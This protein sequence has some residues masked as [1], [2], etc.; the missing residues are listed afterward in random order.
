MKIYQFISYKTFLQSCF[1]DISLKKKKSQLAQFLNC[2][3]GFIS[4]ALSEGKTHFT[5]E[6]IYKTG[7]FFNLDEKEINYLILLLQ[8][9]KAGTV[10]LQKHFKNQID[11]MQNENK[12]ITTRIKKSNRKL[13]DH[14]KA[15]Y[16]S[17]WAYMA[18][19]MSVSLP[20][21]YSQK[22]IQEH[23]HINFDFCNSVIQFLLE[24]G[25]IEKNGNKLS[26]GKTRIHLERNSP[27]VKSLHQNWRQKAIE[28]LVDTNEFNLHYSSVLALSKKD[29]LKIRGIILELIKQKE[30]IL[31]PSPEEEIVAFNIDYFKI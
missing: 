24:T 20:E 31:I 10:E 19:H 21:L 25:L 16:Y 15:I 17:H 14:E 18:I 4:Q 5:T 26:I 27:L 23:F 3:P 30:E 11:E 22:L 1:K 8:Y 9:E 29:A 12:E 13:L 2:Q 7:L 28:S 6:H